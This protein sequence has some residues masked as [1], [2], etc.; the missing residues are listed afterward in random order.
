M[1]NGKLKNI[2]VE[3]E[4]EK[5]IICE[6]VSFF[7]LYFWYWWINWVC[8]EYDSL[9]VNVENLVLSELVMFKIFWKIFEVEMIMI[10]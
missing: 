7:F 6:K 5:V 8:M 9:V 2:G 1:K 4:E 10:F 3:F